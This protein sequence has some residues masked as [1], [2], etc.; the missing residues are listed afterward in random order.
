MSGG[1]ITYNHGAIDSALSDQQSY[2]NAAQAAREEI[3]QM[4]NGLLE[5][6]TGEAATTLG[7][8]KSQIDTLLIDAF[9]DM[10]DSTKHATNQNQL[11]RDLDLKNAG[12]FGA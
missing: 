1:Q 4:F 3:A 6:Y 2:L 8:V 9:N 10:D 11:M 7:K 5:I 12:L